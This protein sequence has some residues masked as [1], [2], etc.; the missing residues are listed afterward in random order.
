MQPID[1]KSVLTAKDDGSE[2][3][4]DEAC[5]EIKNVLVQIWSFAWVGVKLNPHKH[6]ESNYPTMSALSPHHQPVSNYLLRY[7]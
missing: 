5:V 1:C 2:R 7:L 3:G 4:T 6:M